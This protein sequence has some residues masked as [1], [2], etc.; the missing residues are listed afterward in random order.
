MPQSPGILHRLQ[1]EGRGG[2]VILRLKVDTLLIWL[3]AESSHRL[4]T[5]VLWYVGFS[6]RAVYSMAAGFLQAKEH[7]RHL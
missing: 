1:E 7:L 6:M 4:E 5:S 2:A 3:L